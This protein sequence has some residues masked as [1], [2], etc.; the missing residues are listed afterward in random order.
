MPK[1]IK[2]KNV[3]RENLGSRRKTEAEFYRRLLKKIT[4]LK[5]HKKRKCKIWETIL[6][7]KIETVLYPEGLQTQRNDHHQIN[8]IDDRLMV[9]LKE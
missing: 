1:I 2:P 8:T 6:A 7:R 3:R 9:T 4:N 5:G